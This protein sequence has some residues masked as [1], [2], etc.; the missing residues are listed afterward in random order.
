MSAT[1]MVSF[2]ERAKESYE[3]KELE[4]LG[5]SPDLDQRSLI[6][7]YMSLVL[8]HNK[9]AALIP[10]VDEDNIFLRHFCDSIQPLLLFGFKKGAT[11]F[12]IGAGGGFPSIP[13]R[14]FRPD[15]N[16]VLFESN[17]KKAS[18]L[19][20]VRT[21][22]DFDNVDIHCAKAESSSLDIKANYVM[23]RGLGTLQKFSALA[24]PLLAPDGHMYTFKTKSFVDELNLITVNKDEDRIKISEIAQYD[25]GGLIHGLNLVSMEFV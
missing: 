5:L 14:I 16:F 17:R 12:D 18:F 2:L 9:E 3:L 19:K 13:I 15:L 10:A 21:R 22:L 4:K 20:E 23:G 25:L 6:L 11:V 1:Q 24:K 7:T 8:T